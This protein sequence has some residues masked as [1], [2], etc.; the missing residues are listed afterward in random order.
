LSNDY[1]AVAENRTQLQSRISAL[2]TELQGFREEA[3]DARGQTDRLQ[4]E[5]SDAEANLAR[6]NRDLESLRNL[7][8]TDAATI[9][10]QRVRLDEI[11]M[12]VRE[13]TDII[14]RERE[15][16]AAG[17]DIRDLMGA[18]NLR[19]VDVRDDGT[20]GQVRPLAGRIFYTQGRSLIFY[21]YDLQ[22]R[23]NVTRVDFQVWGKREGRSQAPQSLGILYVD[24]PSQNR[25]A[26]QFENA[27]VLAA[28]DQVFVT[29]E[30]RGG[31][32][33]PT[34]KQLLSA[35]FLNESPNHP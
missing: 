13:Q 19:I 9:A 23:G 15:L 30:P 25:W 10:Q 12:T 7:R 16:L 14:A 2:S 5:L 17:K 18:R 21:A 28:I 35:A 26:L 4:R 33:K 20:S 34:G 29:M 24:E 8:S 27:E 11:A 22:N 32:D 31:S 6:A 3:Q 1:A